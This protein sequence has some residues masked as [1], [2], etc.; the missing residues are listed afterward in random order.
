MKKPVVVLRGCSRCRIVFWFYH[1][2]THLD[3]RE[4]GH[5][6][7]NIEWCPVPSFVVDAP[8]VFTIDDSDGPHESLER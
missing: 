1:D 7:Q 6:T 2:D 3:C 4:C 8:R 5:T